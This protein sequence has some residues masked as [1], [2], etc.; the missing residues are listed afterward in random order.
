MAATKAG[1]IISRQYQKLTEGLVKV[2]SAEMHKLAK[3]S[4]DPRDIDRSLPGFITK[5]NKMALRQSERYQKIS[6]NF[7]KTFTQAET[8][9][10]PSLSPALYV[11]PFNNTAF[12]KRM[13]GATSLAY[14]HSLSKAGLSMMS[15]PEDNKFFTQIL[16]NAASDGAAHML[17]AGRDTVTSFASNSPECS[18]Y[19]RNVNDDACEFCLTLATRDDFKTEASAGFEAHRNCAC[20]PEPVY[21]GWTP[22]ADRLEG[23]EAYKESQKEL[24][25]AGGYDNT[26]ERLETKRAAREARAAAAGKPAG[27]KIKA[28][29]AQSQLLEDAD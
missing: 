10:E 3:S 23:Y 1:D 24:N 28:G 16:S 27:E 17:K 20:T 11:V 26:R 18:G 25:E 14:K 22:P 12:N 4:L 5:S 15:L 29:E 19:S 9:E 8:G 6:T 21:E 7:I 2:S 13:I